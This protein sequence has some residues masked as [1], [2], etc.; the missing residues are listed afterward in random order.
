VNAPPDPALAHLVKRVIGRVAHDLNNIAMVWGG[1]LDLVRDGNE[2]PDEAWPAFESALD[3][4]RRLSEGLK[5]LALPGA[6]PLADVDLNE[7]V[8]E[9][10]AE[11]GG[12]TPP[13]ALELDPAAP[14][15][16]GRPADL[17]QAI[18]ALLANARE[19]SPPNEPVRA[20]TRFFPG[21]GRATV[22]IEDSGPGFPT[23]LSRR[24]F[25]PLVSTRGTR[26][27]GLGLS[28]ARLVALLHGGTLT[29]ENRQ[30]GGARAA[31]SLPSRRTQTALHH[32]PQ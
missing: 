31:I 1:H 13:V 7:A 32:P 30:D 29:L 21:E 11:H 9:A 18:R 3:H 15:V 17:V 26:G 27:R 6:G 23:E 4:L 25:E 2:Q 16:T 8:R 24:N 22:E 28:L 10:V 19:A 14:V 5:E 20:R 12:V